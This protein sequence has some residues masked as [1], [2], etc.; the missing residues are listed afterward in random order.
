MLYNNYLASEV[1]GEKQPVYIFNDS[2]TP[3]MAFETDSIVGS[4]RY[5]GNE[6]L[7]IKTKSTGVSGTSD[8]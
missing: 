2:H 3:G 7:V 5:F 8:I 1:F 4:R 6:K